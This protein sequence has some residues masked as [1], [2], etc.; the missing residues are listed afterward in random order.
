MKKCFGPS[1][2]GGGDRPPPPPV[3]PPLE[4]VYISRSLGLERAANKCHLV[5]G[6]AVCFQ[7]AS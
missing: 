1:L 4:H 2:G 5:T 7:A 3:D 6:A